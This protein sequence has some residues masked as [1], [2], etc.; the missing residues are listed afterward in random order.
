MSD[1]SKRQRG[2][3]ILY[4]VIFGKAK[5]DS[6]KKPIHG[7]QQMWMVV[8]AEWTAEGVHA[9]LKIPAAQGREG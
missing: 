9:R 5:N 7:Y 2:I 4:Y 6:N 3:F 8:R 1:K